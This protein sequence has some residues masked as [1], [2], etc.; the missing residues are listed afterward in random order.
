MEVEQQVCCRSTMPVS[1][2]RCRYRSF[3]H[4]ILLVVRL[5]APVAPAYQA[6]LRRLKGD[7]S[8]FEE[9]VSTVTAFLVDTCN[10]VR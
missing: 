2:C 10:K 6:H 4:V 7:G 3:Q 8:S 1:K 5:D 9:S